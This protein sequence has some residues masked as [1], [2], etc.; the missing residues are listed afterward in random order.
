MAN[1]PSVE[2]LGVGFQ[3]LTRREAAK[4]IANLALSAEGKSYVVK[5]YSEFMPR[6]V[7]D[8]RIREILNAAALCLPDGIG[9]VW[10]AHYLSLPGG[11]MRAL[12]QLPLS[13]ASVV[14][15]PAAIRDP[16]PENMAGVDLTWE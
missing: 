11:P 4:A 8:P 15:S 13:L 1:Q 16:L 10:A 2:L 3:P 6:A 12:A 14:L 7:R 9:I 5:P